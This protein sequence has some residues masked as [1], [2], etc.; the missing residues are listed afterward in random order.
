VDDDSGN[1]LAEPA[2]EPILKN[3]IQT[4]T[5]EAANNSSPVSISASDAK[6]TQ[7]KADTDMEDWEFLAM[8]YVP[9]CIGNKVYAN[10]IDV[11]L[12]GCVDCKFEEFFLSAWSVGDPAMLMDQPEKS[13]EL[14]ASTNHVKF[15]IHHGG[16][17]ATNVYH[18]HAHQ[19]SQS[20]DE[21]SSLFF[22]GNSGN[23]VE[24]WHTN[25]VPNYYLA[26]EFQVRTPTDILG[27]HI[28]L[29]KFDVTSSDGAGNG[30]NYEDGIFIPD[31]MGKM[32]QPS[33]IQRWYLDP[34]VDTQNVDRTLRTVFTHDHFEPSTHQQAG[35][36]AGLLTVPIDSEWKIANQTAQNVNPNIPKPEFWTPLMRAYQDDETQIRTL[37]GAHVY[38]HDFNLAGPR[39][40]TEPLW[41]NS[42]YRS[43][44]PTGLSKHFELPFKGQ[45]SLASRT[46]RQSAITNNTNSNQSKI[47]PKHQEQQSSAYVVDVPKEL[48]K[49]LP[50]TPNDK[51]IT[52]LF[53]LY[54][55]STM[56]NG[57]S[58][59]SAIVLAW[60]SNNRAKAELI[61]KQAEA[62]RQ[63]KEQELRIR[64]LELR[65]AQLELD[66]S[67]ASKLIIVRR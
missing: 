25:L 55:F 65:L 22:R 17:V 33:N 21:G 23:N 12:A 5:A 39:W 13:S 2:A 46:D 52:I 45:S 10:R 43:N 42:G 48:P 41:K 38:A 36:Y 56:V 4:T 63:A 29:V 7:A 53:W 11:D 62:R 51:N 14:S 44:Q 64:E 9:S 30:F 61:L 59:S 31:E 18:L 24:Y 67:G 28:H 47:E 19:W 58:T 15:R 54:L 26:D 50:A 16:P 3:K 40:F 1:Q 49:T 34:V 35:F 57:L 8:N 6:L 60:M 37:V 32:I 20:P 27:Q 66:A